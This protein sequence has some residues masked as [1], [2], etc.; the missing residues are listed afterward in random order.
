M[1]KVLMPALVLT[2]GLSMAQ[3]EEPPK[4]PAPD[5]TAVNKRDRSTDAITAESQ[6]STKLDRDLTRKI[7][8]SIVADKALSTYA[9]NVKIISRDGDVTLKGPVRTE[10]EKTTILAK[11]REIAGDSRVKDDITVAP[12]Q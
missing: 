5:N 1:F 7:R 11:A 9:H 4:T 3:Q 12:K 6:K 2:F 10:E 8:Q